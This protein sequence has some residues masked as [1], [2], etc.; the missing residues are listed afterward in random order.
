MNTLSNS[1]SRGKTHFFQKIDQANPIL[2]RT[3]WGHFLL[4]AIILILLPGES[5]TIDGINIWLKPFKFASTTFIYVWTIAWMMQFLNI[6]LQKKYRYSLGIAICMLVENFLIFFKASRAEASHFTP[7]LAYTLMGI[8]ITAHFVLFIFLTRDFFRQKIKDQE[9]LDLGIKLGLIAFIIANLVGFTL[10][11]YG[12]HTIGAELGNSSM[13]ITAW[14]TN[15]GDLRIAHFL[16]IHGLQL[17]PIIGLLFDK[18]NTSKKMSWIIGGFYLA[19]TL[20]TFIQALI[21]KP[22]IP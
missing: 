1:L 9:N 20:F 3:G 18:T 5:R 12:S 15:A 11:I 7:S 4:M 19:F 10:S 8:M 16:G 22:L 17:L 13:P 14:N 21:G 6:G 2:S